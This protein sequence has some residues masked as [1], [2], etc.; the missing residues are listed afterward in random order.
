MVPQ[1]AL[2]ALLI[3]HS[4]TITV[5]S[6]CYLAWPPK[7]HKTCLTQKLLH[8]CVQ[9]LAIATSDVSLRIWQLRGI[10]YD[11][12]VMTFLINMAEHELEIEMQVTYHAA[13]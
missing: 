8:K 3:F 9:Q 2:G 10:K 13:A 1:L 6:Q 12:Q 4:A 7:S 5:V 11:H